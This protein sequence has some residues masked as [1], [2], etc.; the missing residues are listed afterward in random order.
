MT[1]C[2]CYTGLSIHGNENADRNTEMDIWVVD[3]WTGTVP[4][5]THTFVFWHGVVLHNN[6]SN[7]IQQL[8]HEI[9]LLPA[10]RCA[11]A[12]HHI[13]LY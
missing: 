2:F 12:R 10:N 9:I 6:D 11:P 1:L 8:I 3:H 13:L 7:G 5:G 4:N